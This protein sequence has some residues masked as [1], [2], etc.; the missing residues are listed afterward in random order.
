[1]ITGRNDYSVITVVSF[2]YLNKNWHKNYINSGNI[3]PILELLYQFWK[4]AKIQPEKIQ[5]K[6]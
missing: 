2:E 1:M 3:I 6:D 5:V 4:F